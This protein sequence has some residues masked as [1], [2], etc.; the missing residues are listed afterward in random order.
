MAPSFFL[1]DWEDR[2]DPDFDF[3]LDKFS[4]GHLKDPYGYDVKAHQI[5]KPPPYDGILV[6]LGVFQSKIGLSKEGDN[7]FRIR[8]Q[9]SIKKY[10]KLRKNSRIKV[11]GDCGAFT[12]VA[13]NHPPLPFYSVENVSKVYDALGFDYGVS[14]DHM[15]VD[16]FLVKSGP[17]RRR[18]HLSVQEKDRR[19]RL[20]LKNAR[21]F[22]ATHERE[23]YSF[24]PIGV[25]QGYDL[26]TY[27][28]SCQELAKM[29]YTLIGIGSLVR[30]ESPFILKLLR[31]LHSL[32]PEV[33]FHLFGVLRLEYV[34]RFARQG[35]V[36][37]DTASYFRK[38]WLRPGQ[39]YLTP[40][41]TWYAAIRV[42]N[43]T[44][45]RLVK[46]AKINDHNLQSIKKMEASCLDALA[47]YE[48]HGRNLPKVLEIVM[49]YDQHLTRRSD[50]GRSLRKRYARTLLDMPWNSCDCNIC[51]SIGIHVLIFRGCNRNKRRGFHNNWVF[52]HILMNRRREENSPPPLAS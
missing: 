25:A 3:R 28:K 4:D 31:E 7:G 5:L 36:S 10:L 48:D 24:S 26:I 14:V 9:D 45:P 34:R 20:T 12:Y 42:P 49:R 51:T 19:I 33:R 32:H 1:P 17:K 8:N 2:L 40:S 11:L 6:S 39:N 46:A 29:G 16:S 43:S 30:Q 50:D 47:K 38:A 37:F 41:G 27:K 44:D 18:V 52:R 35:V 13:Q 22:L 23:G 21:E 15:A